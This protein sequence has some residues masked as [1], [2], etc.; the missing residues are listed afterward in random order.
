MALTL[1]AADAVTGPRVTTLLAEVARLNE[2]MSPLDP[3]D[4]DRRRALDEH[5]TATLALDGSEAGD[6]ELSREIRSL[7][8]RGATAALDDTTLGVELTAAPLAGLQRLHATLTHGLVAAER[9]G[10]P[11][12]AEQAVQDGAIG[13]VVYFPVAAERV[14][15]GIDELAAW[16]AHAS[17]RH[18][19]VV[20]AGL[21]HLE[22]LRIHPFDAANGRLARAAAHH[23]LWGAGIDPHRINR[24]DRVLA[25]DPLGYQEQVAGTLRRRA[26][27]PWLEYWAETVAEGLRL[28]LDA[29]EV[30]VPSPA[31]PPDDLMVVVTGHG[32]DEITVAD[33]SAATGHPIREGDDALEALIDAGVLRRVRG[34]QG[35]RY[36]VT[37]G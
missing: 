34:S 24:I 36:R 4:A 6:D 37:S 16:L 7:E 5:V 30:T 28:A 20:V 27:E 25:T 23:L 8:V 2:A 17:G 15:A 12:A 26:T 22:L 21:V 14:P 13:R 1:P 3:S 9:Q 11:R 33:L 19:P 31:V 10:R 32:K 35:L 29:L 18:H